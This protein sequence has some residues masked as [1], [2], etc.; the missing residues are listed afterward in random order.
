MHI[1]KSNGETF[2]V[3]GDILGKINFRNYLKNG[4]MDYNA[5]KQ[6]VE[7][8]RI[9]DI[10]IDPPIS[11]AGCID[12]DLMEKTGSEMPVTVGAYFLNLDPKDRRRVVIATQQ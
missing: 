9:R 2:Y 3:P 6:D 10:S 4:K 7:S 11:Q 12:F 5:L 1:V 8:N